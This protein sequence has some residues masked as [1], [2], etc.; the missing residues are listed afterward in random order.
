MVMTNKK[1]N[2]EWPLRVVAS[3][4]VTLVVFLGSS[5]EGSGLGLGIEG[6]SCRTD[7]DCGPDLYC[8]G[9]NPGNACGMPPREQCATDTDC[10]MGVVCHA[11]WDGC[12]TDSIGSQCN[13]PCTSDD[14]CGMG[15]RCNAGGACEP[16]PCDEGTVCPDRQTCDVML[17]H[18]TT[19]PM[20]ARSTGCRNID[21]SD[22]SVCPSGK[23]CVQGYCQ[24][25]LGSCGELII[26]P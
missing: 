13:V 10:G 2:Y 5:C 21:C 24:D 15:F 8:H 16:L 1:L 20:F 23:S 17:A 14:W 9:P 6:S 22:D 3:L 12:S 25:G 26:V 18:D 7:D 19:L 11:T 4:L